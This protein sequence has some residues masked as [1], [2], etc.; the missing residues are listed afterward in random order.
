MM[1]GADIAHIHLERFASATPV[2]EGH[3]PPLLSPLVWER[4]SL[5]NS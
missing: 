1:T 4:L 5:S 2:E 3:L